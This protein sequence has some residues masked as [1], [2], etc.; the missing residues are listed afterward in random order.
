[1]TKDTVYAYNLI[2][3]KEQQHIA[4]L[5]HDGVDPAAYLYTLDNAGRVVGRCSLTGEISPSPLP[6]PVSSSRKVHKLTDLQR[7]QQAAQS[8]LSGPRAKRRR[9]GIIMSIITLALFTMIRRDQG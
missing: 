5:W 8:I 7:A 1:M 9:D 3:P 2:Q 4:E 6:E